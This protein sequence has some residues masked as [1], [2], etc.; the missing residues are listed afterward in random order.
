MREVMD[1]FSDPNTTTIVAKMAS[2]VAKSEATVFNIAGFF[3]HQDPTA[4]M[5]VEPT[6]LG[7]IHNART[8]VG[9][10]IRDTPCLRAVFGDSK[11]RTA[12]NTTLEKHGLGVS[13][14]MVGANVAAD[15]AGDPIR[16]VLFNEVARFPASAGSEG[17]PV[18]IAITR[19]VTYPNR[20][21]GM[22]SSP[23]DEGNRISEA[24]L[25]SDQRRFFVACPHCKHP[26]IL[27]WEQVVWKRDK[28]D[29][30]LPL[31]A[32][33]FC[34][35]DDCD[36]P[37][38]ES[39]RHKAIREAAVS[40]LPELGWVA[41]A[42]DHSDNCP[43][44]DNEDAVCDCGAPLRAFDGTA[45]FQLSGLYAPWPNMSLPNLAVRW[46]NAQGRQVRLKAFINTVLGQDW[47]ASRS[48]VY[49]DP[50]DRLEE[51]PQNAAGVV[52]V[53]RGVILI[54]CGVDTQDDRLEAQLTGYGIDDEKWKLAYF[55]LYGDPAA[56]A[57]WAELWDLMR[58]PLPMERGGVDFIR[59]TCLDTQGHHAQKAYDFCRPRAVYHTQDNRRA[60]LF[61]IKGKAGHA[62]NVFVREPS[63][64]NIGKIPL[65]TLNVDPSKNTL[66]HSLNRILEPGPGFLHFPRYPVGSQPSAQYINGKLFGRREGDIGV[67]LGDG[68][69]VRSDYFQQL[70]AEVRGTK[71]HKIT[72]RDEFVW[73]LAKEGA[74]NEALDTHV[75]GDGAYYALLGMGLDLEAERA[76]VE[77]LSG[78]LPPDGGG[79]AP[80]TP[81][82]PAP[83]VSRSRYLG[84]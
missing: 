82:S 39:S 68:T 3:A 70:T 15:L 31:T 51:Y 28:H 63:R 47:K 24:Y 56:P 27:K 16:V 76:L 43:A 52:V 7:A 8:R 62:G 42:R 6:K 20:K 30:P 80:P 40:E 17:D 25:E 45:G 61:G 50:N 65:Y 69:L 79:S 75:Y 84:G 29:S 21:I 44:S 71:T 41:T 73:M 2:Q 10:M 34:E 49:G 32:R 54:A 78:N 59:S 83:T 33:Y 1:S 11:S 57:V 64:N 81:S 35:L 74:R 12:G 58:R 18:A 36:K 5:I 23:T 48:K 67:D 19:T 53:P 4:V 46:I 38:T 60:Y 77:K 66:Q 37:W 72:G 14:R 22:N 9:P 26:Q 13:L 55:V